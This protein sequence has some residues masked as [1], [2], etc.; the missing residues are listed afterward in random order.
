MSLSLYLIVRDLHADEVVNQ[1][2]CIKLYTIS[3]KEKK[4]HVRK[5]VFLIL[6]GVV[7]GHMLS[8]HPFVTYFVQKILD[9]E[10]EDMHNQIRTV[11]PGLHWVS[12]LSVRSSQVISS[13]WG[14]AVKVMKREGHPKWWTMAMKYW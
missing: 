4:V 9:L 10:V 6:N 11:P 8:K 14:L 2:H 1:L 5:A 12:V 3:Q 7:T 13:H